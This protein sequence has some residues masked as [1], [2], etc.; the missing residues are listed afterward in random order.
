MTGRCACS[1]PAVRRA[2]SC[3]ASSKPAST[4]SAS[5]TGRATRAEQ[6]AE[7]FGPRVKVFDWANAATARAK[8]PCSSTRH[9]SAS[10]ATA[11]S[12]SISPASI[13]DCVVSDIVYVP[14]E[15]ELLPQARAHGLRT[16]DG[17]GMLLHQA[18]P[19]FEKWFGVR[20]EVTRRVTQHHRRRHRGPQMLIVG[21]TGSIGMGKSTAAAHLRAR[22]IPVFDADAEV[23]GSIGEKRWRRSSAHFPAR[24]RAAASIAPS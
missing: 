15:T 7:E 10:R 21:L 8:R 17:L 23:H 3:T 6:L 16:V 4:R 9:R 5:S 2:P 22:G 14:L 11:R 13:A 20:P 19:G 18:V 24:R 12:A 1:A